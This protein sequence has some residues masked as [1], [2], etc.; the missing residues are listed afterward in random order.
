MWKLF[1]LSFFMTRST[2]MNAIFYNETPRV[3]ESLFSVVVSQ[4]ISCG[5]K[6]EIMLIEPWPSLVMSFCVTNND[7]YMFF[8][9]VCMKKRKFTWNLRKSWT[10]SCLIMSEMSRNMKFFLNLSCLVCPTYALIRQ[11]IYPIFIEYS[12]AICIQILG[13]NI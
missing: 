6:H 3:K 8:L 5:K 2:W 4:N 13:I 11:I 1:S 10:C 7:N 9:C 12:K